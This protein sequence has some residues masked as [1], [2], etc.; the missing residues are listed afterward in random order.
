MR[1]LLTHTPHARLWYGEDAIHELRKLGEVV[2]RETD[3]EW[4][5]VQLIEAVSDVD[6][7]VS[8]RS[9]PAPAQLF[10]NCSRL[11]AFVRCAMDTKN[12][13]IQAASDNGIL[14]TRAG[15]GFVP[16][17]SEWIVGQM[18]NL[19]RDIPRYAIDYRQGISPQP[20]M[21]RQLSGKTVGIVGFGNI[22]RYLCPILQALNVT[23]VIY[24][25]FVDVSDTSVITAGFDELLKCSDIVVCLAAYN[26][27]TEKM[28][29]N[30]AFLLMKENA[31]FINASRGGLV[32][33]EALINALDSGHISSAA[34]DVGN[35]HDNLPTK[36]VAARNNVFATPHIGGMVPEA[37]AF[38]AFQTVR[39][40][41]DIKNGLIPEGAINAEAKLRLKR[42]RP[43]S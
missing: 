40:V 25:P 28:F 10:N 14:V 17:V 20:S 19:Y 15:P 3:D 23:V 8:D 13:D 22:G 21:G 26:D 33:E 42:V 30:N 18:I 43:A 2:I 39:Q 36:S 1:I 35:D 9:T 6:V 4:S 34:L 7:V 16:A 12:I 31:C 11:L 41:R 24:D 5:Q 27:K 38:Q 37:I 29:N 32:D